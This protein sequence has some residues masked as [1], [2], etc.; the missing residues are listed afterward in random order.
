MSF[1]GRTSSQLELLDH[2][3]EKRISSELHGQKR[4]ITAHNRA[5]LLQKFVVK[6][7]LA[8][9][10]HYDFRLG[11][12]GVLKSWAVPLGP[13]YYPG[14]RR[15]AV[16]MEDH[17]PKYITREGVIPDGMPGAG[18]TMPWDLGLWEPLPEFWDVEQSLWIGCLKFTLRGEKLKGKWALIR[19]S[20]T[21]WSGR[22]PVWDLIKIPDSFARGKNA[23]SIINAAPNS[24]LSGRSL[25]EVMRL[26]YE[27]PKTREFGG[28]LF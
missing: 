7:H 18:P 12:G 11:W 6:M 22:R 20:T 24:V 9:R 16:E 21:S 14:D 19:R 25:G 23:P 3:S 26:S 28:F 15:E 8:K 27:A 1:Q 10:L 13:S 4:E 17:D 5:V 2:R